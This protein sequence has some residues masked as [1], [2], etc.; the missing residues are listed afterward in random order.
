LLLNTDATVTEI[1]YAL[2]FSEPSALHHAFHKWHKT[3]PS[4]YRRTKIH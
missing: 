3:Q 2:G 1:A 4:A